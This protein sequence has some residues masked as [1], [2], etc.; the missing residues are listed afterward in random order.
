MSRLSPTELGVFAAMAV[1][2]VLG[3][4]DV[5]EVVAFPVAVMIGALVFFAAGGVWK[6]G[7]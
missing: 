4:Y 6:Y 3:L 1:I 5:D 7:C 2:G